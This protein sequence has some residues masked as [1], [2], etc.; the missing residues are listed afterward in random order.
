[1]RMSIC[2]AIKVIKINFWVQL[3]RV[4]YDAQFYFV[5]LVYVSVICLNI[6]FQV[7]V[8]SVSQVGFDGEVPDP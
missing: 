2:F 6:S 7:L 5:I 3:M 4:R 1:M 8:Q